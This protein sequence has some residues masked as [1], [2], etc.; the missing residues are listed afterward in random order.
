MDS[1]T[2]KGKSYRKGG[3]GIG[4]FAFNQYLILH[5]GTIFLSSDFGAWFEVKFIVDCYR[6]EY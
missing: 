6:G 2:E 3:N 4:L 1:L 5:N